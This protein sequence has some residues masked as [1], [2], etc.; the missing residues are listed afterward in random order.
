MD[1]P[2]EQV[3]VVQIHHCRADFHH[4]QAIQIYHDHQLI[5]CPKGSLIAL[6]INILKK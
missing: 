3:S 1:A 2:A 4:H 6:I 5:H